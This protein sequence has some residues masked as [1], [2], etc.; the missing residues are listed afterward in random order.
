M[1]KIDKA[2]PYPPE[3]AGQDGADELT[4]QAL[5][6]GI[7]PDDILHK[8]CVIGMHSI[9]EKFQRNE[10]FVPQLLIAAKAMTC[11]MYHLKPFFVS[12]QIKTKGTFVIGTVSGDLHDIGKNIV[13]MVVEGAGFKVIDLGIDVPESAFLDAIHGNEGCI[14][15]LSA[16]LTTTMVNM[17]QT[18]N[19][20]KKQYPQ[21]K[22]IIGGAPVTGDFAQQIG[23]DGYSHGPQGAVEF[24]NKAVV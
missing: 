8:A 1:G 17:E 21:T 12:G 15:G 10:V 22:V 23:A 2:T 7:S 16:L 3:L 6:K 5:D 14:V 9:G 19:A 18:V 13:C 24:L 4:K 20:I 11:V